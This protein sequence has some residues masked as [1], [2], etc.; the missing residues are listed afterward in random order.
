MLTEKLRG[1]EIKTGQ[2]IAKA[3][4]DILEGW[5]LAIDPGSRS[6]GYALF[7][8]GRLIESD[9]ISGGSGSIAN[10]LDLLRI[11]IEQTLAKYGTEKVAAAAVEKVRSSTGHIYLTWAAG[12]LVSASKADK[13]F[14]V[15]TTMWKKNVEKGKYLKSDKNDA[16]E[17]GKFVVKLAEEANEHT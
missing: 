12:V 10:R 14:E 2:A 16:E 11:E 17:I 8:Q 1:K 13:V 7:Y 5:L 3:A 6:A 4:E 15:T 9:E